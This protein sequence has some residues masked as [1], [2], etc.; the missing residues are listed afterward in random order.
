M[1]DTVLPTELISDYYGSSVFHDK[2]MQQ[3]LPRDI[4]KK[5]KECIVTGKQLERDIA[6]HV[7]SGMKAWALSKMYSLYALVSTTYWKN[8]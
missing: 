8:S 3:F 4:Y 1:E 2:A 7:A 6:D 5:I